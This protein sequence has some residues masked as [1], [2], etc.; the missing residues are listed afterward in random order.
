MARVAQAYFDIL[1]ARATLEAAE[2]AKEAIGRQLEQAQKRFE[3]GL[4]AITDVQEA[5]AS[6]DSAV[7]G[8]IEG[9]RQLAVAREALRAITGGYYT[10]LPMP[11]PTC[12]W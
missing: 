5:Q 9:K 10:G 1:G 12:R 3:V 11:D 6:Y 7:A 2:A 8:V 4:S